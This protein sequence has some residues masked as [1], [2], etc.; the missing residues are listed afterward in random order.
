M[1]AILFMLPGNIVITFYTICYR[2]SD[3]WRARRLYP[4]SKSERSP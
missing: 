3:S 2:K 1:R 4:G